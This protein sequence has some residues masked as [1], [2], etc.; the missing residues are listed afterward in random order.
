MIDSILRKPAILV[1]LGTLAL[2]PAAK[3]KTLYS[4]DFS[5]YL[6]GQTPTH[7]TTSSNWGVVTSGRGNSYVATD[8]DGGQYYSSTLKFSEIDDPA[9]ASI[10]TFSFD[11]QV[12]NYRG[13]SAGGV[14]TFR[15]TLRPDNVTD[16]RYS[17]GLGYANISGNTLFF[18]AG[19][20]TSPTPSAANAIGYDADNGFAEGFRLGAIG[21][22]PVNGTRGN[23]Y[24]FELTLDTG[25][26]GITVITT[27]L[28]DP[29]QI[30]TYSDQWQP[31]AVTKEGSLIFTTGVASQ[32]KMI[33][34]HVAIAAIPEPSVYGLIGIGMALF[35][36]K[37]RGRSR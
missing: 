1:A 13:L 16:E 34:N 36:L 9:E 3:G 35:G 26:G 7:W 17:I 22:Q 27:N 23:S 11:L 12:E 6:D 2:L 29:T 19:A 25:T 24:H 30:A 18:Y 20:G 15:I 4:E 37:L 8:S 14:G 31:I 32:G 33:V 5:G 10:L 21:N 28:S